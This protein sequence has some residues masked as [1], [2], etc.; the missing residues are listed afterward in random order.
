MKTLIT[1]LLTAIM[2][3]AQIQSH[4]EGQFTFFT[5]EQ[6]KEVI[7]IDISNQ[8]IKFYSEMTGNRYHV[9]TNMTTIYD[10]EYVIV[11]HSFEDS[12]LKLNGY[13]K[14][15][16]DD[17]KFVIE[18]FDLTEFVNFGSIQYTIYKH[19]PVEE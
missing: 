19:L 3:N 7:H 11:G 12:N 10:F 9:I 16:W 1:L 5:G 13:I 18:N 4:V 8:R 17:G 14:M 6:S 15:R 2:L